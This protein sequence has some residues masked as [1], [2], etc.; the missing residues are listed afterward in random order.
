MTRFRV[1]TLTAGLAL[2]GVLAVTFAPAIGQA[3]KSG[4]ILNVWH[5]ENPPSLSIHEEATI[6]T[7]LPMSACYNNLVLFDPLKKQE[8]EATIIPELAEKWSWQDGGRTLVFF[9]RKDV[10]WHDGQLFTAKDVKYTFDV[11]RAAPDAPAKLRVNPRKGWYDNVVSIDAP[12]AYTVLFRLKRPQPSLLMMLASGYSP[13]YPAHVPPAEIRNRCVG[14]GPFKVKDYR[15]GEVLELVK[16]PDYFVKGRPYLDGIRYIIVKERGTAVAAIQTGRID[17]GFPGEVSKTASESLKAAVPQLVVTVANQNVN[18]NLIMNIRRLPFDNPKVRK[19]ISLAVDRRAYIKAVHQGGA[20]PGA[21]MAPKPFGVWGLLEKDLNQLPGYGEPAK[22]KAEAKK[23]L[24][25]AGFSPGNPLK[26]EMGTRAIAIYVDFASFIVDQLK[27]VGV[28]ATLKQ[29]ETGVW[30]PIV[31]RR[32]YHMGTNLTGIGPDDPD[33]NFYENYRCGSP[34]NYTDYCSELV[35]SMM[36]K[37][38]AELD[39]KKRLQ[40]VYDIQKKLEEEAARP[41]MGWRVD[42]FTHWPYV[43]NLIPHQSIYNYWR[44]QEVWL[45]K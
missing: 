20:L 45:D 40:L 15:Q 12:D 30:H 32:E 28:E 43:K 37:Q 4:G 16:N 29:I 18:D 11:V 5:R 14:T 2:L 17:V 1:L 42:Y 38:S 35:D 44:M 34:R 13:V 27:Q 25:E 36:D 39:P 10:K 3:P 7:V 33:A 26:V 23:L 8:S 9:L 21:S 24:A 31:T 41:I 19:A 6:S 22:D